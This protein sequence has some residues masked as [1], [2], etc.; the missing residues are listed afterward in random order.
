MKG[1]KQASK[2]GSK[3]TSNV[4]SHDGGEQQSIVLKEIK[5]FTTIYWTIYIPENTSICAT[6]LVCLNVAQSSPVNIQSI[7]TYTHA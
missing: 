1:S 7:Y 5:E 3:Q 2:K 6:M 4:L